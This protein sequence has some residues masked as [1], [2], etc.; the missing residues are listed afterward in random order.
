IGLGDFTA[1]ILD[2]NMILYRFDSC[3]THEALKDLND[4][5]FAYLCSCYKGDV[6][7]FNYK[8]H[9]LR[10][11]QTLHHGD[12]CDELYWN[13]HVHSDP[14]Q[15]PLEFTRKLGKENPAKLMAEDQNLDV[16][17]TRERKKR[18]SGDRD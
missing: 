18:S 15:P 9:Y 1:A 14:K 7:G 17:Q 3:L 8:N 2:D 6:E 13:P 12:F 11:T 10:R 4:P 16:H 5:D